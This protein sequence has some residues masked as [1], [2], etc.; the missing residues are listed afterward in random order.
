MFS[1]VLAILPLAVLAVAN[2][3][4]NGRDQ[5]SNGSAQ[6]CQMLTVSSV[7]QSIGRFADPGGMADTTTGAAGL[8][9]G[10][11]RCCCCDSPGRRWRPMLAHH[12][13]WSWIWLP[14]QPTGSVLHWGQ[15]RKFTH[16]AFFEVL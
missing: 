13:Y 8:L 11:D 14:G 7:L 16:F 4:L 9:Q 1:R 2:S 10:R 3:H 15:I 12:R 5:C 6:C